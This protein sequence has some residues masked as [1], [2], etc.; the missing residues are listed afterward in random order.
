M[1]KELDQM[2]GGVDID[3]VK[4]KMIPIVEDKIAWSVKPFV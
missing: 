2:R 4:E 3:A 1:L